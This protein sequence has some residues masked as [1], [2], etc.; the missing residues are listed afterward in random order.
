MPFIPRALELVR[1]AVT[2][3]LSAVL[4]VVIVVFLTEYVGLHYLISLCICFATVTFISFWLNRR[5]TFR[6]REPGAA[7]DLTRYVALTLLQM[8]LATLALSACVELAH[9]PYPIAM[10][11]LSV[12]FVPVTFVLHRRWSFGLRRLSQRS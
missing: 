3:T 1:F 11:L 6:K 5:W 10:L 7:T 8:S 12:A 9:I 4:N 2:G